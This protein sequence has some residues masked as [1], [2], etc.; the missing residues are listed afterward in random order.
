MCAVTCAMCHMQR[1]AV[2]MARAWKK[3]GPRATAAKV[4]T[5]LNVGLANAKQVW[6]TLW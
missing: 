2:T 1:V 4:A 3:V 6:G 5:M